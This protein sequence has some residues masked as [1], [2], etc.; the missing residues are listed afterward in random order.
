[1]IIRKKYKGCAVVL[2]FVFLDDLLGSEYE[3]G[4]NAFTD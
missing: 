4:N 3:D 2:E 1:M